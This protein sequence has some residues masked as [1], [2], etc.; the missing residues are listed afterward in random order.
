MFLIRTA[1]WLMLLVL[2]L[3][4]NEEDQKRLFGVAQATVKDL[5]TFCERNPEVCEKSKAAMYR[6]GEKAEFG[7]KLFKNFINEVSGKPGEASDGN[8]GFSLFRRDSQ[9]TLTNNDLLPAW[10]DPSRQKGI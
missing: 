10:S 1:F 2:I 8:A 5:T 9:D 3:P 4:A 7:S 6:F